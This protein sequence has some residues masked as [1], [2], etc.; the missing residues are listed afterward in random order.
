MISGVYEKDSGEIFINGE[1]ANIE[2]TIDARNYGIET[3]YQDQG[4]VPNFNASLNLFL[5]KGKSL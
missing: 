4:L 1:K 5:G 2:T 3:V